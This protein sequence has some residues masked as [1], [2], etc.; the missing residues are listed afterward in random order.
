MRILLFLWA[1]M[2]PAA[3]FALKEGDT[4]VFYGDSITDQRLYTTFAE[5]YA[6]TRFPKLQ[7]RFVHSG[8]GGDRVTGGGGG[9]IDVRLKR[10]VLAYQP[11]VMTIMLGMNDG[12]YRAF[13]K[14]IFETY[15]NGFEAMVRNLKGASPNLRITAII[16]SPYDDVTRQPMFPGGYNEVLVRYGDYLKELAARY[17][18]GTADLN[19][20]VVAALRRANAADAATAAKIL[21]D[22]VHPGP[23]G[24]L[25]MA[26][27]LLK[28]WGA[29]AM[30]TSLE[31]DANGTANAANT[32]VTAVDTQNGLAW[33]QLDSALPMPLDPKDTTLALAVKSSDFM[34]T[35]NQQPLK[36]KGLK[37]GD[38]EL[39]IDGEVLGSFSA[40]QLADGINLAAMQ[41]PMAKQAA[42]VHALTLKR[43]LIHNTR[44]RTLQVPMANDPLTTLA[45]AMAAL[46]T[47]DNELASHQRFTAQPRSRRYSVRPR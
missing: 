16:P 27:E 38:Y 3:D 46:D 25:L 36:V 34:E 11:T 2:L 30:V 18:L 37:A 6:I 5:T 17:K 31:I 15:A 4:V 9:P 20:A 28:A 10:D 21:P 23:A 42:D 22:R 45:P 19:T 41:T 33:T 7:V 14:E 12:R 13:D 43:S 29:P 44:W 32:K 8:W 47:L 24:H 35:L 40:S 1:A 26:A 39:A